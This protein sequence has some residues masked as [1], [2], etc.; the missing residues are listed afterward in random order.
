[1]PDARSAGPQESVELSPIPQRSLRSGTGV[2]SGGEGAV[3]VTPESTGAIGKYRVSANDVSSLKGQTWQS[4]A[5]AM[6]Y[7]AN[8]LMAA[9]QGVDLASLSPGQVIV[10]PER[11]LGELRRLLSGSMREVR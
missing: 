7:D 2:V 5:A 6:G 4:L 11:R 3:G 8:E 1:M 9:N 10:F